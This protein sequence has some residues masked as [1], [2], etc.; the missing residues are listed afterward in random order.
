MRITRCNG[1]IIITSRARN[2]RTVEVMFE[3]FR[4]PLVRDN[5]VRNIA[6]F[7]RNNR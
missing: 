5:V 7:Q 6:I 4:W 3:D 1:W 2:G